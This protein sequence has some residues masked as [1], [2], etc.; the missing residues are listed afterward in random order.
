MSG[1]M[2]G[3]MSVSLLGRGTDRS[4]FDVWW[5]DVVMIRRL[6]KKWGF[7]ISL[8]EV[9][10]AADH[11]NKTPGR[12]HFA[13]VLVRK[14]YAT[15]IADAFTRFLSD[16]RLALDKW[17][18]D[19][20]DAINLI[21]DAGG[22]AVLAHPST[23]GL[24]PQHLELEL[25]ALIDRAPLTGLEVFSSRHTKSQAAT[26]LEIARRT[27]LTPTGGSDYHGRMKANAPLG[28]F[29][30]G[31]AAAV[32]AASTSDDYDSESWPA[33]SQASL[34]SIEKLV[35]HR[36]ATQ[37]APLFRAALWSVFTNGM[38]YVLLFGVLY[39]L[40][41]AS[42]VNGKDA[43]GGSLSAVRRWIATLTGD[44]AGNSTAASNQPSKTGVAIE[45]IS[46][47]VSDAKT[48]T[49]A[50][51][52]AAGGG[53]ST[54]GGGGGA[55]TSDGSTAIAIATPTGGDATDTATKPD[56]ASGG[57]GA[58]AG[59]PAKP[60]REKDLR[61]F[62]AAAA[63]LLALL[64]IFGF[65]QERIMTVPYDGDRFEYS[66]LLVFVNR[67]SALC[68][69]TVMLRWGNRPTHPHAP[70]VRYGAASMSNIGSTWAQYE[71]LRFISFPLQV[72]SKTAKPLFTMFGG[73][74]M[75]GV[76]YTRAEYTSCLC[77]TVGLLF[78]SYNEAQRVTRDPTSS[79]AG[80]GDTRFLVLGV[81]LILLYI[82]CD[83]YTSN[84]QKV[85]YECD[86]VTEFQLMQGM[87]ACAC[88]IAVSLALVH[89]QFFA[90]IE[91]C[92]SHTQCLMHVVVMSTV[93]AFSQTCI[94]YINRQFGPM[95]LT[96]TTTTRQ[97]ASSI[98]SILWF[99][100]PIN[101]T[102]WIGLCLVF[103]GA[104]ILLRNAKK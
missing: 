104:F 20:A 74:L 61:V 72:L 29:V 89:G 103:V 84:F 35:A 90:G 41:N 36:M 1:F 68:F 94:M 44:G 38:Q 73:H 30:S 91:F 101:A 59:K 13:K 97:F 23:L 19:I 53:A 93:S 24:E 60:A 46:L 16:E 33:I 77:L 98:L 7:D 83:S 17:S 14:G 70:A 28:T 56:R 86:H 71:A 22:V 63:A 2:C 92:L 21:H 78:F 69:A 88:F 11:D 26:F 51:G 102:G 95:Y 4:L 62:A 64:M 34:S 79:S 66:E 9:I 58:G 55:G 52:S 67:F 65:L 31:A 49:A 25:I 39:A 43:G 85:I 47:T 5:C 99:G 18:L 80:G 75:R 10:D 32:A 81:V 50:G 57:G 8:R 6:N 45:S 76:R 54:G 42:V 15:S 3:C 48:S 96:L 100:H 37:N 40:F 27:G 12:P 87:N 82:M